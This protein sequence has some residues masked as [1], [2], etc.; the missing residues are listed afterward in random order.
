MAKILIV[1]DHVSNRAL[2][3]TLILHAGHQPLEA[4]DGNEAL[5]VV[6]AERPDL[7]ISDILMPTMD[8]YEF[9]RQLRADPVLAA[10]EV[11]FYTAH[12]RERNA[13]NLARACGVSRVLLKPCDPQEILLIIN[14]SLAHAPQ[15]PMVSGLEDFDRE[16]LRLVTD[17]LSEK[18]EDLKST[19]RRLAALTDL[20]LH[21]ASEHDPQ[22]L[23][24]KVCRGARDLFC[25]K[26]VVLG[27]NGRN[28]S[29]KASFFTSGINAQ[30]LAGLPQPQLGIGLLGKVCAEHR[31]M[32]F[33]TPDGNPSTVGLP[34]GYP[35]M[36]TCLVA[37]I[38]SPSHVYGWICLVDK[39]GAAEFNEE[40]EQIASILSAQVGRIY[41]NGSLY[42]T[43]QR[44]ARQ[45]EVEITERKR[46]TEELQA[47]EAGLHR[48]QLMAKISHV[49]T[50]AD[51]GFESWPENLP[52]M[53]G[54]DPGQ[55]IKSTRDWIQIIHPADRELFRTTAIEAGIRGTRSEPIEYRL[56]RGDAS[57]IHVRQ[58]M[59]PLQQ[60]QGKG[61]WFNTIQDVTEQKQAEA[62]IL[63]L[64][65]VYA[66]LSGINALIVRTRERGELFRE[67]C[68]IAVEH[69]HFKMA[70]LG[71]V[72]LDAKMIVPVASSR[73]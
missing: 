68:H 8:G 71:V 28:D 26:Y 18:L 67:A 11:V 66:V 64:N 58:V 29:G 60:Q 4:A 9:V 40:D 57:W 31:T 46:A 34:Q 2:V 41:E 12:Y 50:A 53:I 19:N 42:A 20:N 7:I 25:A 15:K 73:V 37:P 23:L 70:W 24:D 36:H 45:L 38:V 65:R 63:R 21:L 16:H 44:H 33:N 17:K 62:K 55:M 56:R 49:V 48:A 3:V 54:V 30:F 22:L 13:H 59:E 52:E 10:T 61:R 5:A 47:K 72:D 43:V 14:E 69:G 6:R 35:S 27:V 39:M 1:D 32:R 51:G